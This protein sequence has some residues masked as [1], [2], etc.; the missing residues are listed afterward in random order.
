VSKR[1]SEYVLVLTPATPA[2]SN[3]AR[4]EIIEIYVNAN[5]TKYDWKSVKSGTFKKC[6][7]DSRV[8]TEA[9]ALFTTCDEVH[10]A[11][12]SLAQKRQQ[13]TLSALTEEI[14]ASRASRRQTPPSPQP[15][16]NPLDALAWMSCAVGCCVA[17]E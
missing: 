14:E 11:L 15:P 1:T 4:W 6:E 9:L 8:R 3:R 2:D 16:R 5:Q 7:E 10:G 17:D 12:R 13:V